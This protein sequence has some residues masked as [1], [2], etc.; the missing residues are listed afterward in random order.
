MATLAPLP[1]LAEL[2]DRLRSAAAARAG[3]EARFRACLT[4]TGPLDEFQLRLMRDADQA[5]TAYVAAKLAY[6]QA[7]VYLPGEKVEAL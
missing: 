6:S 1:T 5:H 7:R 4:R 3:A 2:A